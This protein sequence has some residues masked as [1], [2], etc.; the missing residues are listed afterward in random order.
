MTILL[1]HDMGGGAGMGA[2]GGGMGAP[3]GGMG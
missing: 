3:G 1:G 2:P